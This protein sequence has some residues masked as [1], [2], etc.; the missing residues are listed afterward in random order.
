VEGSAKEKIIRIEID[1]EDFE[2]EGREHTARELLE[3]AGL[4]PTTT[5]LIELRGN[6]QES[7]R[8]RLDEPI[9]LHNN[10]RFVSAD[11]GS[12]PVA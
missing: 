1:G 9:K 7:Y 11:L 6:N 3:L 8:D 4:D 10:M 5:Y 2:V 12:A